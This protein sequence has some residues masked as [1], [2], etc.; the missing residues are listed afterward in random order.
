MVSHICS[1]SFE[2]E[3][4]VGRAT[5]QPCSKKIVLFLGLFTR[6][7][8]SE[9]GSYCKCQTEVFYFPRVNETSLIL[10]EYFYS[11]YTYCVRGS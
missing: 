9:T 5:K 6:W 8:E 4:K 2:D 10:V 11:G 3:S 7:Q 1:C